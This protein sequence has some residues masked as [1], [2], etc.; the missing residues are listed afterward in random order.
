MGFAL[1][2]K[3][4][5]HL[6]DKMRSCKQKNSD[7]KANLN[8]IQRTTCALRVEL[9]TPDFLSGLLGGLDTFYRRIIAIY[10]KRFPSLGER[11]L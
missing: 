11:I 5:E 6:Y 4:C 10:E 9:D 3:V 1:R 7:I 2:D 8:R